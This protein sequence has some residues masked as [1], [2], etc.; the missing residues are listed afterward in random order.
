MKIHWIAF[1]VL[2]CAPAVQAQNNQRPFEALINQQ[3]NGW[4]LV[5]EGIS[6]AR[7]KVEVLPVDSAKAK[8]ALYKCQVT[9]RSPMGAIVF[10]TG[11]LLIDGGWIR[12]LGS[13][14]I[15][16]NRSLPDWNKGKAFTDFGTQP[17]F[18]L[19][20]DDASGGFFL[21]NGGGLGKDA[22]KV[23]YWPPD[24]LNL[25]P[26]DITYTEFLDFCF[27]QDLGKFYKSSRWP[28]WEK[29]LPTISGDQTI[30]F[31]PPLWSKEGDLKKSKRAVAP[32]QEQYDFNIKSR[33]SLGQ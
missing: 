13:G 18:L 27:N 3:E 2:G 21:L 8:D 29:D 4:A 1:L 24:D 25:E 10:N 11:G 31:F 16:L 20:A 23:Y 28:G 26:M 22:G 30:N 6:K 14:S 15:K 5:A 12:V 9:T 32:V 17:P 33:E 19:I 7:N